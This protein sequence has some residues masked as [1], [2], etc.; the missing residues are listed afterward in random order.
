MYGQ[1]TEIQ[2]LPTIEMLLQSPLGAFD[3]MTMAGRNSRP[4]N[5]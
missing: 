3:T 1:Q 4:F 5:V 2:V